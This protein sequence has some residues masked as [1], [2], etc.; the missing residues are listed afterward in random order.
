MN[1]E[2]V[3][4]ISTHT[5]SLSIYQIGFKLIF[6]SFFHKSA[7]IEFTEIICQRHTFEFGF[8]PIRIP[9]KKKR[10][11]SFLPKWYWIYPMRYLKKKTICIYAHTDIHRFPRDTIRWNVRCHILNDPTALRM[12]VFFF[13]LLNPPKM[14]GWNSVVKAM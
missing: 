6:F 5:G 4:R 11:C 2:Q 1:N 10:F 9:R 3:K 14:W 12:H 7:L 8:E 13:C